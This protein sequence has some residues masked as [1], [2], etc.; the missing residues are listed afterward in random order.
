MKWS[1]SS[2]ISAV[3]FV[4]GF[5]TSSVYSGTASENEWVGVEAQRG[6]VRRFPGSL[7]AGM[8]NIP[9]ALSE[10]HAMKIDANRCLHTDSKQPMGLEQEIPQQA[11]H[12][13]IQQQNPGLIY[14]AALDSIDGPPPCGKDNLC[15]FAVC[16][17]DPDCPA[18]MPEINRPE[19][20]EPQHD[21]KALGTSVWLTTGLDGSAGGHFCPPGGN[22]CDIM[23]HWSVAPDRYDKWK[24]CWK[25]FG[26]EFT[27]ACDEN[28][29]IR[30][31]ENNFFLIPNL[32]TDG[33]YRIRLE[34]RKDSNDKWKCL[35]KA[36]LESIGYGPWL[37]AV[38]PCIVP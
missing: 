33:K 14:L 18:D 16:P 32:K 36:T 19:P 10:G 31:F 7:T 5:G 23:V 6:E 29:K 21:E 26:T 20:T 11:E 17:N 34:G 35:T 25:E 9:P 4:L 12:A 30:N 38:V 27:D 8:W 3:V 28:Q 15:N 24:I 1:T 2:C 22:T 13:V 37:H